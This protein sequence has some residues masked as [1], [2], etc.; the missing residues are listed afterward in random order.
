MAE[1][2]GVTEIPVPV[3]TLQSLQAKYGESM[4]RVFDAY[5]RGAMSIFEERFIE[6]KYPPEMR[7]GY[8][9]VES[10]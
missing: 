1:D 4:R 9:P 8:R 5:W 2:Y 6:D 3:L 7:I 10:K